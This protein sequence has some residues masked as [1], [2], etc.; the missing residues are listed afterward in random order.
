MKDL[1][2]FVPVLVV[3]GVLVVAVVVGVVIHR[4][5][6]NGPDAGPAGTTEANVPSPDEPI[7]V[8]PLRN[9]S[10]TANTPD[11]RARA[12]EQKAQ[13]LE[14]MESLTPEE[15]E[16]FL[17]DLRARFSGGSDRTEQTSGVASEQRRR[18]LEEWDSLPKE[19]RQT[20]IAEIEERRRRA[21][22]RWQRGPSP[23]LRDPNADAQ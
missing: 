6:G 2:E 5:Q 18:L 22:E 8:P 10:G 13:M 15:K 21:R 20:V 3:A 9:R 7:A 19:Q 14:Q 23:V 11:L 16:R 4:A 17:S 12:K 1:K